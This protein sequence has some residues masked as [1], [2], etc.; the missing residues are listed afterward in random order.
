M[1]RVETGSELITRYDNVMPKNVCD[2]I[3]EYALEKKS[4]DKSIEGKLPWK[5][6]DTLAFVKIE[7]NEI[8][9][10]IDIYRFLHTQ[11]VFFHCKNIVFPH[12]YDLVVWREGMKMNFHKDDGYEGEEE[13]KFRVRKYSMITYLNDDYVGGETV[14]KLAGK[15]DYIS[16]PK[17]GSVVI[18]KSNEECIHGVNEIKSG[19]RVTLASWFTNDI[20]HC[21][22]M[23]GYLKK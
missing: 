21:E 2:T 1:I 15:P 6:N 8:K 13:D 23:H 20:N 10:L 22:T 7:N 14:I 3:V 11:L 4:K 19:T 18:F 9:K 12:F 16:V 17:Q 5:N